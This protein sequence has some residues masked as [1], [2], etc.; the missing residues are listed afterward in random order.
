MKIIN[1]LKRLSVFIKIFIGYHFFKLSNKKNLQKILVVSSPR[2]GSTWL[3]EI[4]SENENTLFIDEPL[5][6]NSHKRLKK[7]GV[8]WEMYL[9]NN[10]KEVHYLHFFK[11]LFSLN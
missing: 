5:F 3:G 7:V 2:G 11:D 4:L 9:D 6:V 10:N 8:R 1:K